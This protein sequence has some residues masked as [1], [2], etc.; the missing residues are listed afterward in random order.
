MNAGI[1]REERDAEERANTCLDGM[2]VIE[3]DGDLRRRDAFH[4]VLASASFILPAGSSVVHHLGGTTR[5]DRI[6][7][8][9]Q[10]GGLLVGALEPFDGIW[11]GYVISWDT[12]PAGHRKL[13]VS[14]WDGAAWVAFAEVVD[15]TVRRIVDASND[16]WHVTLSQTGEIHWHRSQASDWAVGYPGAGGGEERYF[17]RLRY[18][19]FTDGEQPTSTDFNT[20]DIGTLDAPGARAL[21]RGPARS[22]IPVQV[23]QTTKLIIGS[24][25]TPRGL[26]GGAQLG[27]SYEQFK[28]TKPAHL[29]GGRVL[30]ADEGGGSCGEV[31]SASVSEAPPGEPWPSGSWTLV[32]GPNTEGTT[33]VFTR[34]QRGDVQYDWITNQF[35]GAT[36]VQDIAPEAGSLTQTAGELRGQFNIILSA[37]QIATLPTAPQGDGND[38]KIFEGFRLRCTVRVAG[39]AVGEEREIVR[40][41]QDGNPLSEVAIHYHPHF[42]VDPDIDN[43]FDIVRPHSRLEIRPSNFQTDTSYEVQS[44]TVNVITPT[45]PNGVD[46][47][48][49]PDFGNELGH[50]AHFEVGRPLHWEHRSGDFWDATFDTTTRKIL[51]TNG[52]SWPIEYDGRSFR[53]LRAMHDP[54]NARVQLW[55]GSL[56]DDV[57]NEL[58]A[59][60]ISGSKLRQ[61]PPIG[62]YIS[63]WQ[64]RTVL[65]G[66]RGRP[67]DIAYSAPAPNNDI[68]PLLYQTQ[69]RDPFNLPITGMRALRDRMV[70]FT[71]SSIH[72]L[73]PPSD[74]GLLSSEPIAM[75]VGFTTQRAVAHVGQDTLIGAAADG[76]YM[77]SGSDISPVLEEWEHLVEGGANRAQLHRAVAAFSFQRNE[78]YIAFPGR[79]S[80]VCDKIGVFNTM[81]RR[82]W[83]WEAPWGGVADIAVQRLT[84][85][86][87][88]LLFGMEDGTIA[89]LRKSATDD[90]DTITGRA[91][92]PLHQLDTKKYR[93]EQL[94]LYAMEQ[95][96]SES[97]TVRHFM[98]T[99][100]TAF[101]APSICVKLSA[102]GP[103]R[104]DVAETDS[105]QL[106]YERWVSFAFKIKEGAEASA[107]AYEVEGTSQWRIRG[108]D[109]ALVMLP[110]QPGRR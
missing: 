22:V 98:D 105:F 42:T 78:F 64:G 56:P 17:V 9:A 90:G 35:R 80:V 37:K 58:R 76:V 84:D 40:V 23:G 79:G 45:N 69:V 75:G 99:T 106:A 12:T 94:N 3:D 60:E 39:T 8:G 82:W 21:L 20:S 74:L 31:E 95:S 97:L 34:N 92:S 101:A 19:A 15:T 68:W 63:T 18:L 46:V 50:F 10:S 96:A 33:E 110:T 41:V 53:R 72:G 49:E 7:L 2:N 11:W 29:I 47:Q 55:V 85:G 13:E 61:T 52:Q 48:Y 83:C 38:L 5:Y 93:M 71:P 54:D 81:K 62:K 4:A 59:H 70:V 25:R 24:D 28:R 32:D 73:F 100:K 103:N 16:V 1:H 102:A 87:E 91:R 51:L 88:R 14:Y 65:A 44:N 27:V 104:L 6:P 77:L 89:V 66:L 36:V 30:Q 108:A 86:T 43:R 67:Y 26:E 107:Y 57:K 109:L